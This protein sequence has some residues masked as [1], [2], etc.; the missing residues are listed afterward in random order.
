MVTKQWAG[1]DRPNGHKLLPA[2]VN[3][4]NQINQINQSQAAQSSLSRRIMVIWLLGIV[5]LLPLDILKLPL[6]TTL[7]DCWI[8]LGLPYFWLSFMRTHHIMSFSYTAAIWLVLVGSFASTFAAPAPSNS[9]VVILKEVYI[10]IWFV[11]VTAVLAR[12]NARDYRRILIV[13][14]GI[15]FL[16]G[17]IIMAQFLSPD[18]WRFSV[19]LAAGNLN[20]FETYRP[21]GLFAN[22]NWAAFFQLLGFVPLLLARPAKKVAM[23]LGL[24]LLATMLVTGSL[25]A[26][27]AFLAG[28]TVVILIIA[29]SGHLVLVAK[30]LGQLALILLLLGALFFVVISLN[31]RYQTHLEHIFLGR[32]ERSSEG[33]FHLWQ[34]GFDALVEHNVLIWGIGPENF[35]EVDVKGK[36]LHNDFIAFSVER[37]LLGVLGLILFAAIAVS[38]ATYMVLLANR[39]PDRARLMVVVFLGAITAVIVESLTHQSFHFREM[40]VVLAFQEATLFKMMTPEVDVK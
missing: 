40:W 11:T 13:W 30:T 23:T 9:L 29:L 20:D 27:I 10:F 34:R 38:R 37:G 31:Q 32:A 1:R 21:T 15:V 4:I 35:R 14:S 5:I 26:T 16:H 17:L 25:G 33:R 8:L 7:V 36:Q 19:K 6:N 18:F 3:Q 12:L 28:L 24:V 39:D 22:A 2:T